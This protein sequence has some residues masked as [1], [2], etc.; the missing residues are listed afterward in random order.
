MNIKNNIT[1]IKN[2]IAA[3]K[4]KAGRVDEITL[5]AVS[6]TKSVELI[7]QA[8]DFGQI[9]FGENRVQE[10]FEKFE[11]LQNTNYANINWHLIGHL[12]TNKVKHAVKFAKLIHSVDSFYLAEALQQRLEFEAKNNGKQSQDILVQINT[13]GEISKSGVAPENA[14]ELIKEISQFKRLNIK[15]LMTIGKLTENYDE[16]SQNEI[17]DCFKI[18]QEIF[19]FAKQNLY[20]E[21]LEMKHLSMGMSNDF[22]IAIEHG[23]TLIRVGSSIFGER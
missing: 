8:L 18:C 2:K 12:Q 3:A 17:R 7:K 19:E 10:A 15:G 4:Q 11:A 5:I 21:N 22:E 9:D 14:I 20:S 23:A 13:S 6:K 16:K 1:D